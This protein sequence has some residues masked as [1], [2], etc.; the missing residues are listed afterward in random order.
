MAMQITKQNFESAVLNS[1]LPVMVDFW[2]TWCGPCKML[3]PVLDAVAAETEGRLVVG[4]INVDDDPELAA[5]FGVMN[6]PTV[7]LFRGG[8]EVKRSVGLVPKAKLMALLDD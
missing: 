2:A 7:I 3:A 8:K 1:E 4:K 6:I 5:K